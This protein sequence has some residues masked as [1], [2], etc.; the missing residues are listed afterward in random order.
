[1]KVYLDYEFNN[2]GKGKF[3]QRLCEALRPMGVK[4]T[5]DQ[6]KAVVAL[7]ISK[8]RSKV[9]LPKV[10]RVDG[11]RIESGRKALWYN[12]LRRK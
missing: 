12:G 5:D 10:L 7:G 9:R 6:K 8:W 2:T 4:F 3:L 11:V 1:M